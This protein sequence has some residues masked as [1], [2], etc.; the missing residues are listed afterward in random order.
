MKSSDLHPIGPGDAADLAMLHRGCFGGLAW[1][2]ESFTTLLGIAECFGWA[3]QRPECDS[4]LY[5]MVIARQVL[6]EAEILTL[7]VDPAVRRS[8]F[9]RCLVQ[10]L[11]AQLAQRG[12]VSLFLE[13]SVC[14]VPARALYRG[15]G[16]S[17][18]GRRPN[19]YDGGLANERV[20]A[21]MLR[22]Q[23]PR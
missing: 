3:L 12:A 4:R 20:D 7:C 9:A 10:E 13:V 2:A 11:I 15:F 1:N 16:F 8:G 6:D 19:Y 18:V 23:L 17:E 5:A 21:C 14:N 22:L